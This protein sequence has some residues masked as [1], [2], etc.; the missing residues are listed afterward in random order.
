[1][2]LDEYIYGKIASFFT[3]RKRET[4]EAQSKT[5]NLDD[6]KPR[7]SILARAITG[8][9]IAVDGGVSGLPI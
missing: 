6:I 2:A 5:V 4:L 1:M 8:Q 9:S 3:K 7:L